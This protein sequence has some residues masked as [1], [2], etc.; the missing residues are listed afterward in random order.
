MQTSANRGDKPEAYNVLIWNY[1][2][3]IKQ[4]EY[5]AYCELA[6]SVIK[7]EYPFS[8]LEIEIIVNR[9]G[10]NKTLINGEEDTMLQSKIWALFVSHPVFKKYFSYV[11]A[12][13]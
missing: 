6:E 4:E 13:K 12:V 5:D 10:M 1:S 11:K 3:N 7:D 9:K 2:K 8:Q